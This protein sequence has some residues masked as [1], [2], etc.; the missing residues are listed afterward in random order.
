M[1]IAPHL[2]PSIAAGA[3]LAAAM[4]VLLGT[5]DAADQAAPIRALAR[6]HGLV[7]RQGRVNALGGIDLKAR[8][9]PGDAARAAD[10]TTTAALARR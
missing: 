10:A 3:V 4:L 6:A 2:T 8:T 5:D 1:N 7:E 9:A